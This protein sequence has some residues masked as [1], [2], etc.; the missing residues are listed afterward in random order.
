MTPAWWSRA[1]QRRLKRTRRRTGRSPTGAV[2][3]RC[4]CQCPYIN[5]CGSPTGAVLVSQTD[6]VPRCRACR[7]KM[8]RLEPLPSLDG[9]LVETGESQDA[10]D[11]ERCGQ[12]KQS[13]RRTDLVGRRDWRVKDGRTTRRRLQR[14]NLSRESRTDGPQVVSYVSIQGRWTWD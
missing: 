11:S 7:W 12:E 5:R 9:R 10:E 8:T 13:S 14:L 3:V 2:L 1:D 4:S 6:S